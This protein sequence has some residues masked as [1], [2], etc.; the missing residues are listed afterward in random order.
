MLKEGNEIYDKWKHPENPTYLTYYMF[1]L[2]NPDDVSEGGIPNVHQCG[3]Y[4]YRC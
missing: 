4:T 1:N 2:T 3:P